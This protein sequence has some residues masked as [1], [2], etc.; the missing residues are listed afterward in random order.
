MRSALLAATGLALLPVAAMAQPISGLYIGAAGGV[1]FQQ[2][3]RIRGISPGGVTGLV[4]STAGLGYK[5]GYVGLGSIGWGFG[6]GVRLEVEGSYRDNDRDF[7][8]TLPGVV[9]QS[10]KE[11]KIGGMANVLFDTDIGSRYV[12]PYLGAGA[13]Y[14]SVNQ[15]LN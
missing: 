1:G 10:G 14:Q 5:A 15:K 7:G 6:N 2:P 8:T 11:T 4:P 9:G 13:G 3:E 12:F